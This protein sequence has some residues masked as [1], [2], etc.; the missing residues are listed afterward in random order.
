MLQNNPPQAG[1]LR[2]KTG[3]T[4]LVSGLDP[5]TRKT[6]LQGA[7]GDF[8]QILRIDVESG[9]AFV[10]FDDARDAEDAIDEMSGKKIKGCVIKVE[11]SAVKQLSD[12]TPMHGARG[13]NTA[14]RQG[15]EVISHKE[16]LIERRLERSPPRAQRR[17]RSRSPRRRS[18]SR[19]A[20]RARRR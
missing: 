7:F 9:R 14:L 20:D 12:K 13:V 10:E 19:S 18:R 2:Y 1:S 11:R 16:R 17:G 8:G 5:A 4:I 3:H 6:D 15:R